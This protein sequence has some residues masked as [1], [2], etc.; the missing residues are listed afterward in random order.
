LACN[1]FQKPL[2]TVR[3]SPVVS[4][5]SSILTTRDHG[6]SVGAA[7]PVAACLRGT[8]HR[9]DSS[10]V[11]RPRDR[12]QRDLTIPAREVLRGVLSRI[13]DV[14]LTG[15]G[16]TGTA[17]RAAAGTRSRRCHTASWRTSS[18]L[19]ATRSLNVAVLA[20]IPTPGKVFQFSLPDTTR[21]LCSQIAA[22]TSRASRLFPEKIARTS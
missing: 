9:Y 6:S 1:V 5:S 2:G 21:H 4:V 19:R 17:A 12:S 10:R 8:S 22:W 7:I 14:P 3:P 16:H 11:P 18:P 15:Q 13:Q 20:A